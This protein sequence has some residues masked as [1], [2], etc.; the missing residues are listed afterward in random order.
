MCL[1][2]THFRRILRSIYKIQQI[3]IIVL[4][5]EFCLSFKACNNVLGGS[6]TL[7]RILLIA[8]KAAGRVELS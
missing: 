6:G 8:P 1:S 5:R 4:H 7:I 2:K 3:I